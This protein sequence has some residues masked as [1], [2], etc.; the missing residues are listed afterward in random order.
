VAKTQARIVGLFG[1][2]R[3]PGIPDVPTFRELGY[4]VAPASLGGLSAP[5]GL[6]AEVKRKLEEACKV[7][8]HSDLY[9]KS[10]KGVFQP[11]DYYAGSAEYTAALAEDAK[12]KRRLLEQVGMLKK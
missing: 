7:A 10:A 1:K 6:P 2:Q 3:N 8:A 12:V 4:D 5:A 9:V 11:N